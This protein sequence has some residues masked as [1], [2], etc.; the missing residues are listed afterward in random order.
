MTLPESPIPSAPHDGGV[1]S[2]RA[3][4]GEQLAGDQQAED[5][6]SRWDRW[7]RELLAGLAPVYPGADLPARIVDLIATAH[8]ARSPRLRDR[9]R[10]R[11]LSPDWFQR[12]D[13]I[14]YAAYADRFAETLPG[15][16]QRVDYLRELGVTYLHLMPLLAP[17]PGE[18]DGGY[19]VIDY[20]RVRPDLGTMADLAELASRLHDEGISLTLDLVLNHVAAEHGWADAA[21]AGDPKYRDYFYVYPDRAEPDAY[22]ATLPEVFPDFAPGNFTWDEALQGWVWTTFNSWQ[23]DLNWTNPDVLCE[24]IEIILNLANH[25]VDCLRLDAIAFTWKRLGTNCQN[26]PEVHSITQALRAAARIAAPSLI[27]KAEAI[28]A[29]SDLVAYLGRGSHA[30]RV[31]DI[32]Y[33]NSLMVQIWSA[34][35]ARDARLLA[36]AMSRFPDIPTTTGWATYL[37]CH[38]DIGWS[39]ADEDCAAIGWDGWGHRS[40]LSD[41]YIGAHPSSFAEGQ[42]FQENPATGDRRISGTAASLAG[43]GTANGSGQRRTAID[44]VLLGYAMV[45]GFGGIPLIFMGD[46]LALRNDDEF[47]RVPEHADDN[48][49]LHRP[50]MPWDVAEL[51]GEPQTD[52]GRMYAGL[53]RLIEVRRRLE[54]LHG[55]VATRV[56]PTSDPAVVT[57]VRHHPAGDM[58]QVY[59][60]SDRTISIAE[61]ELAEHGPGLSFDQLSGRE[62]VLHNGQYILRPYAAW[63]LTTR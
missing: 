16:A 37:R 6:L 63:W 55:A 13:A 39:V 29:P 44:R 36:V 21:R 14:G 51:R 8:R 45:F 49:W 10:T 61:S 46:E 58:V 12:P 38:D 33:H 52:T 57:F 11:I 28:V 34:L 24:F 17:R 23:W 40:F 35:A 48:R 3:Q 30:G 2:L 62:V 1:D 4:L 27:F 50:Q 22:E 42:A 9:D 18:N 47:Y 32:A 15:V 41:F 20:N 5:V 59:N 31:C 7:G 56:Y 43:L 60:V 53:R 19:A 25:G 54:S 26:E